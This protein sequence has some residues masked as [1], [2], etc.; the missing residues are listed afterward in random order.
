MD[1]IYM[2]C[3][4]GFILCSGKKFINGKVAYILNFEM[5]YNKYLWYK[6]N[7]PF[8]SST[9]RVFHGT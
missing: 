5:Y 4:Y 7:K 1:C 9:L 8:W 2:Q 3:D 6:R